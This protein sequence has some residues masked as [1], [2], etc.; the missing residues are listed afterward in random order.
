MQ[1]A[2]AMDASEEWSMVAGWALVLGV[3]VLIVDGESGRRGVVVCF[4][5]ER[6]EEDG[7]WARPH[8]EEVVRCRKEGMITI[9]LEFFCEETPERESITFHCF[10]LHCGNSKGAA[11]YIRNN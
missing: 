6:R 7:C 5:G 4:V 2:G 3:E 9:G 8:S 11:N 1:E 10:Q